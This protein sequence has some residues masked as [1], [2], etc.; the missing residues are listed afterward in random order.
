[1]NTIRNSKMPYQCEWCK[2]RFKLIVK[3]ED[4]EYWCNESQDFLSLKRM[5]AVTSKN[6]KEF[7]KTSKST[8][9]LFDCIQKELLKYGIDIVFERL[10]QHIKKIVLLNDEKLIYDIDNLNNSSNTFI[11]H[12]QRQYEKFDYSGVGFTGQLHGF[13][14]IEENSILHKYNML[15]SDIFGERA[16]FDLSNIMMLNGGSSKNNDVVCFTY[17]ITIPIEHLDT[18]RESYFNENINNEDVS[19]FTSEYIKKIDTLYNTIMDKTKSENASD[20]LTR[21]LNDIA[22]KMVNMKRRIE[23]ARIKNRDYIRNKVVSENLTE[24][25]IP[26]G[27]IFNNNQLETLDKMKALR[28]SASP[29]VKFKPT[30]EVIGL[31][32][33]INNYSDELDALYCVRPEVFV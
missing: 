18:I 30:K 22:D 28:S 6:F 12:D 23:N 13:F 27:I 10:P 8:F 14:K 2:R 19:E 11:R 20:S 16:M 4:H 7:F 24:Y 21:K 29:D 3:C 9:S 1:M 33:D 5:L 15:T 17:E 25:P 32:E 26:E 31:Y